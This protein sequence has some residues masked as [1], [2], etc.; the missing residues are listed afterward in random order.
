[1]ALSPQ[2][3]R[4]N[5]KKAEKCYLS[6]E[7]VAK[8]L[9]HKGRCFTDYD[10]FIQNNEGTIFALSG[11]EVTNGCIT[12]TVYRNFIDIHGGDTFSEDID[13]QTHRPL[14]KP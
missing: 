3:I 1:M 7:I 11:S 4:E 10:M 13:L 5:Y 2:T 12:D 9:T 8:K 6:G 14:L